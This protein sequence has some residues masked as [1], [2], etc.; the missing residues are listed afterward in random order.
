ML[1]PYQPQNRISLT[2]RVAPDTYDGLRY[3]AR[4]MGISMQDTI[5]GAILQE[6]GLHTYSRDALVC[7]ITYG[8]IDKAARHIQ[9]MHT[10]LLGPIYIPPLDMVD[11][12]IHGTLAATLR[13]RAE[14]VEKYTQ[15]C[16]SGV[17]NPGHIW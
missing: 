15:Y 7:P 9:L 5:L 16:L 8:D 12:L 2:C 4:D 6:Y 17:D 10:R 3:A 11:M 14:M 13:E 1:T